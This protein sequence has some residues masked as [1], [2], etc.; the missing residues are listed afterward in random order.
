MR[1]SY[2]FAIVFI[3]AAACSAQVGEPFSLPQ[4][5]IVRASAGGGFTLVNFENASGYPDSSLQDWDQ[6]HYSFFIQGLFT[7]KPRLRIG[8][9]I[10]FEQLYYW[11]YIIPYG[12]SPVYREAN[13]AT[14]F[15]GGVA[16]YFVTPLVYILGGADLHFFDGTP[17]VGISLAMGV[18]PRFGKLSFPI[19]FRVKPIIG[20]AG[21][22]TPLQITVGMA[23]GW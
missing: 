11:Y 21:V 7:V 22:P 14:V 16:Q 12:Y 15:V 20:G 6:G 10:G 19:E 4:G 1:R 8:G 17:A 5:V 2:F 23:F 13:W 9:E 3:I 18:E